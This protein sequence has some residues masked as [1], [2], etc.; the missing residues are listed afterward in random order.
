M[1]RF[2]LLTVRQRALIISAVREYARTEPQADVKRELSD[3]LNTLEGFTSA[4]VA[5]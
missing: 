5:R 1:E 3:L 4:E 2:G